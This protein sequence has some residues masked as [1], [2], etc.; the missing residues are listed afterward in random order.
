MIRTDDYS[1][2]WE[3]PCSTIAG[4]AR[5]ALLAD[6]DQRKRMERI[7]SG[8]YT[9][10]EQISDGN[11]FVYRCYD[12]EDRANRVVKVFPRVLKRTSACDF[13]TRVCYLVHP[14][15]VRT[16]RVECDAADNAY[17]VMEHLDGCCAFGFSSFHSYL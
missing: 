12:N 14:N 10:F 6:C 15:V 17:L 5:S 7:L 1:E 16:M 9:D 13:L 8:R 4:G 3:D 2:P 11:H